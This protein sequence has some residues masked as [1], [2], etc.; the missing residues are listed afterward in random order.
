MP[1]GVLGER[2]DA[3]SRGF[4]RLFTSGF[5]LFTRVLRGLRGVRRSY[6]ALRSWYMARLFCRVC[7]GMCLAVSAVRRMNRV[8]R[9]VRLET[10][11]PQRRLFALI[12]CFSC[13]GDN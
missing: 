7:E 3:G 9:E 6:S 2:P 11:F 5:A 10:C 1:I 13:E 4:G 8:R 12:R